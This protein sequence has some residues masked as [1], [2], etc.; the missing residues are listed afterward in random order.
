MVRFQI[1][2]N[3]FCSIARLTRRVEDARHLQSFNRLLSG[4]TSIL[5]RQFKR[6]E[7]FELHR[8]T[9]GCGDTADSATWRRLSSYGLVIVTFVELKLQLLY[10][11]IRR[12]LYW[13]PLKLSF[14]LPL[15]LKLS[16]GF[17][18]SLLEVPDDHLEGDFVGLVWLYKLFAVWTFQIF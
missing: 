6:I 8:W 18:V 5:S 11:N 2:A 15:R 17:Q 3:F 1:G 7:F 13:V 9:I 14:S 12:L 4:Y 16:G 10:R